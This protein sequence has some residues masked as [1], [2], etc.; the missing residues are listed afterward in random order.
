METWDA[1]RA[2]R[3]VR[4]Y[5]ERP[6]SD[7]DLGRI[8]EAGRRAPSAS[9][10]Q[11]W[12]FVVVSD[13]SDL[14][15]LALVWKGAGHIARSAATIVIVA[16]ITDDPRRGGLIEY[17]LG[18]ATLQMAVTAADLGIGSGHA[19]I[20]DQDR[21]RR[22]LGIPDDRRGAYLLALGYPADKPLAP[23][24]KINRRPFEEVVHRGR[25]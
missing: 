7:G 12:D 15:E 1:I 18:Q 23:L 2:R 17:D 3:N 5:S 14:E 16:P 22:L 20:G 21:L 25:W 4:A 19:A 24:K 9:N 13:K 11:P 8:L 6:I 10:T